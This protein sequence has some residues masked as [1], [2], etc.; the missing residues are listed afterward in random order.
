MF[1]RRRGFGPVVR[2]AAM[3]LGALWVAAVAAGFVAVLA[4][5]ET[6]ILG[7][8][9]AILLLIVALPGILLFRWGWSERL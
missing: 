7:R 8:G 1:R 3:V 6:H 9:T 4:N 5:G 2:V